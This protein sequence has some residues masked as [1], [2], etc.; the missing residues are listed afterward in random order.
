MPH[1][2]TFNLNTIPASQQ[3]IQHNDKTIC[4]VV[5]TSG[6]AATLQSLSRT[7]HSRFKVLLFCDKDRNVTFSVRPTDILATLIIK[8]ELIIWDDASMGHR[9]LLEGLDRLL[10]DLMKDQRP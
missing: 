5:A 3:T 4:L 6:S 1:W 7:F 2:K 9:Q 8:S 10:Q